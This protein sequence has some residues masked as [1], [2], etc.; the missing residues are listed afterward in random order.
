EENLESVRDT[1]AY[2]ARAGKE[3]IFDAEHYFDGFR[4]DPEYSLAVLRA[5]AEAGAIEQGVSVALEAHYLTPDLGGDRTTEE[6]TEAVSKW[7]AAGE[8]VI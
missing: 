5:A 4:D 8:G 3:V 1:V 7:V 2:L 6:V